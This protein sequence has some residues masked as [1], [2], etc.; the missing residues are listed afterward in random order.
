MKKIFITGGSGFIGRNL[1]EQLSNGYKIFA[2]ASADINLLDENLVSEYIKKNDFDIIIH[3]ATWN[4]TRNSKKNI[5]EVLDN[6]CRM[7]FNLARCSSFYGKM[8]YY[9]S[10]A[11]YDRDHWMPKMNENYFDTYVP[12][13]G[14]GFSKYIMELYAERAEN[15]YNLRLFGVFGKYE[16]WEIRFIS[17]ACCK[18][19]WDLP[20][21]IKQ[22]VFFDYMYIDDLVKITKWFI[23]NQPRE[24]TYNICSGKI[25]DLLTLTKKILT[26]SGKNLDIIIKTG[27]FGVEYSGDNT[28]LINEIGKHDFEDMDISIKELYNWYMVN[29]NSIDK[30]KLLVDK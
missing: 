26:I 24:K 13:D 20:I 12:K 2:P 27:G 8:I 1:K 22:N 28:K 25:F 14:Y 17:N 11:E 29:K 23:E 6:N 30:S 10:G 4:A 19:L 9:G 3:C 16:D 15:I 7:F 5:S 18:A 21:T